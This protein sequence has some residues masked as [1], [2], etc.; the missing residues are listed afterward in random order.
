MAGKNNGVASNGH[1][2]GSANNGHKNAT[3]HKANGVGTNGHAN[4]TA[5]DDRKPAEGR[6][7]DGRFTVGN[8]GGP[9]NP[10]ARRTAMMRKAISEAV[11][12]EEMAAVARVMLDR[13]LAGDVAAARWLA[14]YNAGRH[15]HGADPDT[16]DAHELRVRR[17]GVAT[18]EDMKA[19]F[20][21][22]PASVMCELAAKVAEG[23]RRHM[24]EAFEGGVRR[25]TANE[26]KGAEL[27]P[28]KAGPYMAS[29]ADWAPDWM[30]EGRGMPEE[31][32]DVC[33]ASPIWMPDQHGHDRVPHAYAAF[34]REMRAGLVGGLPGGVK[35]G[36][37]C[38]LVTPADDKR[39]K[40][41]GQKNGKAGENGAAHLKDGAA[42]GKDGH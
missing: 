36:N 42:D 15:M 11:T 39:G 4:D 24:A 6:A 8:A 40:S 16:L 21:R 23:V 31:L 34:L 33:R 38:H 28:E 25:Q 17:E 22:M 37:E 30:R 2:N 32:F 20:E 10:F 5:A 19:L 29:K 41:Q 18:V 27:E 1:P 3:D 9:G 12:P 35:A 14:G 26:E 13:A 7:P